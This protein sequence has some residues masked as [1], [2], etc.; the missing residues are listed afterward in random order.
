MG[1]EQ[2]CERRAQVGDVGEGGVCIV[3]M[4]STVECV[5]L[6][7]L[8]HCDGSSMPGD[9]W[10]NATLPSTVPPARPLLLPHSRSLQSSILSNLQLRRVHIADEQVAEEYAEDYAE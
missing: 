4:C 10:H 8:G 2:L 5:P 1:A 7:A 3:R 6:W 9:Q